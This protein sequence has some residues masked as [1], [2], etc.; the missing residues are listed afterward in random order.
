MVPEVKAIHM[1]FLK[2]EGYLIFELT[3]ILVPIFNEDTNIT[4]IKSFA[5]NP[6]KNYAETSA[7]LHAYFEE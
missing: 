3:N 4:E 5:N 7:N 1:E 2:Q 6:V